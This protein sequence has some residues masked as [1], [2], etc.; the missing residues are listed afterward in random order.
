MKRLWGIIAFGTLSLFCT[1]AWLPSPRPLGTGEVQVAPV[2]DRPAQ[3]QSQDPGVVKSMANFLEVTPGFVEQL[4]V[5]KSNGAHEEAVAAN[6][7]PLLDESVVA[8]RNYITLIDQE[9]E[10]QATREDRENYLRKE[11][12]NQNDFY[13]AREIEA[14][15]AVH[16]ENGKNE[17]KY[18]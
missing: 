8:A 16:V 18:E 6:Q 14:R 11:L 3:S 4:A 12:S 15:L 5:Q 17:R 10:R 2:A 13:L 1:L 9:L 7:D